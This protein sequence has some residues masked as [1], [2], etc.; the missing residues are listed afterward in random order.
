MEIRYISFLIRDGLHSIVISKAELYFVICH[1]VY[2]LK[3]PDEDS[4][5]SSVI[6]A[7]SLQNLAARRAEVSGRPQS[8]FLLAMV[9]MLISTVLP[10]MLSALLVGALIHPTFAK[11]CT[12]SSNSKT[13]LAANHT[14]GQSVTVS[15]NCSSDRLTLLVSNWGGSILG[16]WLC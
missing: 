8:H 6:E 1:S 10:R 4:W 11:K 7:F 14:V 13:D 3:S 9:D 12:N 5:S 16:V 2:T 15:W